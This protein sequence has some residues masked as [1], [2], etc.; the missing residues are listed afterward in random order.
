MPVDEPAAIPALIVP[1]LV[2][3]WHRSLI[4]RELLTNSLVVAVD[5]ELLAIRFRDAETL[6]TVFRNKYSK[7]ASREA[8]PTLAL[9][10]CCAGHVTP[11][12]SDSRVRRGSRE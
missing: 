7:H 3:E 1:L 6:D 2:K 4:V 9:R 11:L 5:V 8:V 10:A 12:T